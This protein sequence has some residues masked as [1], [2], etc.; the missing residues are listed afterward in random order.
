MVV[1]FSLLNPDPWGMIQFDEHIFSNGLNPPTS[2]II[3]QSF[4]ANR[5]KSTLPET[6]SEFTPEKT[7]ANGDNSFN[8]GF[9]PIF[10]G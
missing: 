5:K 3:F 4:L 10:R 2:G 1:S 7:M 6:N 9:G 8:L